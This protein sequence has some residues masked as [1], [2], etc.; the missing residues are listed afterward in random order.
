MAD[1]TLNKIGI[2]LAEDHAVVREG[3]ALILDRVDDMTVVGEAG[4]GWR[5]V[6]EVR[7]TRPDV[8]LM[9]I[10]MPGLSGIDATRSITESDP[11]IPV[12]ILTVYAREDLLMRALEAGAK[13]YVLKVAGVEELMTAIRTVHEGEVYIHSPMTTKLV[14]DYVN[15][16]RGGRGEDLY[17]KLSARER[18]VL[19]MLAEGRTVHEV[20]DVLHVSPYTV[21]TYRQRIMQKL[22]VHSSI[23]L[24]MY[25]LRKGL[26]HL[27]P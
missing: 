5:T 12:I 3:I 23:E 24:L 27:E 8:V 9:D 6:E 11:E 20:G 25:A 13:G 15:R 16:L 26:V 22:G 18:Q 7:R 1:R 17:E 2:F 14:G 21:Q 10:D 4:D 19:P